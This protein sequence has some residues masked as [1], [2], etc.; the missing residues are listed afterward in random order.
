MFTPKNENN[1]YMNEKPTENITIYNIYKSKSLNYLNSIT[2]WEFIYKIFLTI[3]SI[4]ITL[5][6]TYPQTWMFYFKEFF[7]F[8]NMMFPKWFVVFYYMF[9][10]SSIHVQ[11]NTLKKMTTKKAKMFTLKKRS[12]QEDEENLIFWIPIVEIVK[13]LFEEKH[14]KRTDIENK[15]LIPRN[16][17]TKLASKLEQINI[18]KRGENNSRILNEDY[19]QE[20]ILK[21]FIFCDWNIDNLRIH[22]EEIAPNSFS[23]LPLNA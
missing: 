8:E 13:H 12:K 17:Y 11:L 20:Q 1:S 22:H 16:Q 5:I 18:L 9:N 10:I 14:F 6:L 19:T 7:M 4:I 3:G 15:F 21:A 23:S 2:F